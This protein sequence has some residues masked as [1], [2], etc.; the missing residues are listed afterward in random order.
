MVK[1]G[2]KQ[3]EIGVI[4]VDWKVKELS[5]TLVSNADYGTNAAAVNNDDKLPTYLRIT[6]IDDN[7]SFIK[8]NL[9][10][11]NDI[12]ASKYSLQENEIVFAR[13]GASVGKTYLYE[14][15]DGELV[16]AGFLIRTKVNTSEANSEFIF[17][18]PR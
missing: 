16:F 6:D 14:K 1:Q 15:S 17:I 11:V 18:I 8:Y 3:T 2:Y 13:T 4:P 7:G 12:N 5:E 10:S 9:S